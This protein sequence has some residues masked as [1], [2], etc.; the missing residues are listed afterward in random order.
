MVYAYNPVGTRCLGVTQPGAKALMAYTAGPVYMQSTGQWPAAK[1]LGIYNCRDSSGG[2]GLSTHAEGRSP[3]VGFP[4]DRARWP[5]GHPSGTLLAKALTEHAAVEE[6][7]I[8]RVIWAGYEW[9]SREGERHWE[10]YSGASDHFDHNHIELTWATARYNPL[11]VARVAAILGPYLAPAPELPPEEDDVKPLVIYPPAG[12]PQHSERWLAHGLWRTY[13]PS[14]GLLNLYVT[15]YGA[16]QETN[17]E[18]FDAL[19]DTKA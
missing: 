17:G 1:N 11:T 8:Q 7:G 13:I 18:H 5:H 6:L 19:T 9:D 10:P 16:P 3:D 12:H 15:W 14:Q 4:V 2:S